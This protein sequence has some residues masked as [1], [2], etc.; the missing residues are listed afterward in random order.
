MKPSRRRFLRLMAAGSA[1]AVAGPVA[2]ATRTKKPIRKTAAPAPTTLAGKAAPPPATVA[3]EIR[4]QKTSLDKSLKTLRD[5]PLPAGSEPA[6]TFVP[7]KARRK[8]RAS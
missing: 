5:Y 4:R 2:A 7:L 8:E 3:E 6:F 1:A